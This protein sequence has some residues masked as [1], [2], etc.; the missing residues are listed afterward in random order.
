MQVAQIEA[1]Q[2]S[3][4]VKMKNMFGLSIELANI[5]GLVELYDTVVCDLNLGRAMPAQFTEKDFLELKYVQ[6]YMFVLLYAEHLAKVTSTPI[7]SAI[8]DK[9]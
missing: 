3:F 5:G 6:N 4:A 1:E 8:I 9:M 2:Q 7:A